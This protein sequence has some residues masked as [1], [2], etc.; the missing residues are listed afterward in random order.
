MRCSAATRGL[1]ELPQ[2]VLTY[3]I[4]M[5]HIVV[6]LMVHIMRVLMV[7]IIV[8]L[9]AHI[10]VVLMVHIMGVLNVHCGVYDHESLSGGFHG[11]LC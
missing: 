2:Q 9:I 11:G 4:L 1:R 3:V 6:I 8:M 7:H 10:I 5:V